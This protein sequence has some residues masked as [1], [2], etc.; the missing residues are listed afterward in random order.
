MWIIVIKTD[1]LPIFNLMKYHF[2]FCKD[3]IP[4]WEESAWGWTEYIKRGI[5]CQ[6]ITPAAF[7]YL[8]TPPNDKKVKEEVM[9]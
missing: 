5:V 1:T 3:D 8:F 4:Q 2:L 6:E 7:I 9:I